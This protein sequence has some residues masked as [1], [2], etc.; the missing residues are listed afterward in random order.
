MQPRAL[1]RLVQVLL[2]VAA[3]AVSGTGLATILPAEET[4]A[5]AS[6][7]AGDG[8]ATVAYASVLAGDDKDDEDEDDEDDDPNYNARGQVLQVFPDR[9]PPELEL[10]NVDGKMIVK[11]MKK[12]EI[13]KNGIK[14]GDYII[15]RGEKIT[16]QLFEATLLER[17]DD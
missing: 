16:E 1:L 2:L 7:V 5:Y 12:D 15:A 6:V 8:Q 10:A 3:I 14:P 11:V 4:L 17:D 13:A 9:D